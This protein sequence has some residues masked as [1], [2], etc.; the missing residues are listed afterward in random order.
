MNDSAL[1]FTTL[2]PSPITDCPSCGRKRKEGER[3][4]VTADNWTKTLWEG[5]WGCVCDRLTMTPERLLRAV[6]A[7]IAVP[8]TTPWNTIPPRAPE[9]DAEYAERI[10]AV[11]LKALGK[12]DPHA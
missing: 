8:R 1:H 7:M 11:G 4:V 3:V 2:D 9:S 10:L 6:A 5:C 12:D